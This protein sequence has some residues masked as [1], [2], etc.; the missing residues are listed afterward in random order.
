MIS[1]IQEILKSKLTSAEQQEA[2]EL[3]LICANDIVDA[4]PKMTIKT[5][6]S[7]AGRIDTLKQAMGL[8]K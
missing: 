8:L 3:V 4:W 5:I 7:M 2:L 1:K 6:A